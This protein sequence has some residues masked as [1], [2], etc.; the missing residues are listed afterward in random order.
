[1]MALGSLRFVIVKFPG[2]LNLYICS[3]DV[4]IETST[5]QFNFANYINN[6]AFIFTERLITIIIFAKSKKH[7]FAK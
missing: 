2:N 6:R 3:E 4:L 7:R 5:C 1:M